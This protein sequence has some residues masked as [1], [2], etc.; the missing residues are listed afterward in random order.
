[1]IIQYPITLHDYTNEAIMRSIANLH[2]AITWNLAFFSANLLFTIFIAF[3][4]F[5]F[6]CFYEPKQKSAKKKQL[7]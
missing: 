6:I 1:M 2:N 3:S 4:I 7:Q 5:Y